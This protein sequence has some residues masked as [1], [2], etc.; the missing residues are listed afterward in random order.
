MSQLCQPRTM[1]ALALRAALS[2][3]CLCDKFPRT[4][5]SFRPTSSTAK[6]HFPQ[7]DKEHYDEVPTFPLRPSFKNFVNVLQPSTQTVVFDG[8]PEDPYRPSSMPIYQT[9]T[10]VQPSTT[11]VGPCD[12]TRSG[13][14]TR[15]AL[16]TQVA[17]LENASAAFA[18]T[19]GMSALTTVMRL[20]SPGEQLVLGHDVY[21]GTYR[22][23]T[24][25]LTKHGLSVKLVDPTNQEEVAAA[26]ADP[27]TKIVHFETPSNPLME[28]IDLRALRETIDKAAPGREVLLS[29][30]ATM[31][32]PLLMKPFELGAN[33]VIHS[34]TKFFGGH[35]DTMGGFVCTT[36]DDVAKELAFMQNAEGNALAPFDCWLLLRGIKTMAL[37]VEKSMQNAQRVADFLHK[38]SLVSKVYYAGLEDHPGFEIHKRQ[39]RGPG[40]V[41]S[42][43]TGSSETSQRFVDALRIFKLTVSF[44]SVNSLVELPNTMSHASVP[45]ELRTIP[46]DLVRISVGIEDVN[47]LLQDLEQAFEYA[48]H[49]EWPR[50]DPDEV[51]F[52]S[53]F[54]ELPCTPSTDV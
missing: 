1:S 8:C 27:R 44:G 12:Y 39:A 38:H 2:R 4:S 15:T 54:A 7:P 49:K 11:E 6:Q 32:T 25:I 47:D 19:S 23:A 29:I 26:V 9:S 42:F 20:M 31:M 40:T 24:K 3:T 10:F 17:L 22:L 35:A 28:I 43:T 50:R 36:N 45:E 37:R 51:R 5:H 14:P 18:F 13:N 48:A 34:A 21:G 30:D 41:M 46:R 53:E 16:E 52:T 33:I